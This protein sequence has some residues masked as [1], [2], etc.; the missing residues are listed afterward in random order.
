MSAC[1][2]GGLDIGSTT[3]KLVLLDEAL[4]IQFSEYRR[5]GAEIRQT[6]LNLLGEARQ[7][8]G[9][10][11]IKLQITGSGGLLLAEQIGVSFIQEVIAGT[12]AI[13]RTF[14]ETDVAIELGGEDAKITFFSNPMEQR[15]NGVCAGGTG[16]FIDQMAILLDTDAA[17]LNE[18]AKAYTTIHPI[19]S[20][21]G[22]FAKTDLQPLLNEGVP[23][24]DLAASIFQAVVNQTVSGLACGKS[25]SGKI[26]LL[27][28]P[29]YFLS[30][31]RKRFQE[32]LAIAEADLIVPEY[33]HYMVA[34]GTAMDAGKLLNSLSLDEVISKLSAVGEASLLETV[35]L[36]PLFA[37]EAD[38]GQFKKR[39]D[40]HKAK[41]SSLQSHS[42]PIFVGIDAGSTTTKLIAI[43]D[44]AEI[45]F[46]HYGSNLGSPL[47]STK[48]ALRSLYRRMPKDAFIGYSTVTGYGEHLL[49]SALKID[50]GEIETIA[51]YKAAEHFMPGVTFVIDIGGQDM[52]SLKVKGGMIESIMLN[53]ACSSG[54]GSFIETFAK[55]MG[56]NVI[57]F[58]RAGLLAT[59]PVDLGTRCTVF[60][61]S[62]VKQA[63]KEGASVADIS[64]GIAYSVVKNA[65]YKVI[66]LKNTKELGNKIVVQGGTFFN[67]AVLRAFELITGTE[68]VRPDISGLMGA[69]GAA[70]IAKDNFDSS[71]SSQIISLEDLDLLEM[72]SANERC[73]LCGNQCLL[74]VQTFT[75]GRRFVS[76]NRCERGAKEHAPVNK[77]ENFYDYKY[78][79]L[80]SY[81]P[82]SK[83]KA[84]R[85]TVGIPRVLNIYENYPF[86]FRFFSDL[87]FRVELSSRSS[88]EIYQKG[89]E[90]IPSESVCYPAKL[91]HGHIEDLVERGAK[92][93]FYPSIPYEIKES[94]EAD[95]H[96]N[97]PIVT[98]Y[99]ETIKL[100]VPSM[101]RSDIQYFNPFLPLFDRKKMVKIAQRELKSYD[102]DPRDIERAVD[103]AYGELEIYKNDL[104]IR[105]E[106]MIEQAR[107]EG[108]KIIVLS[109]RPYHIDPE[110]NH[111]IPQMIANYGL[112]VLSEDAITHL[113]ELDRPLR[114][115]DQ[116]AYHTRLYYAAQLVAKA[117]DMELVQ[118]TSFGCGLDA[119]T[120]DQVSEILARSGKAHTLLK[121]DEINNL[122]AAR[123]RIRS[124][125]AVMHERDKQH[126]AGVVMTTALS[127]AEKKAL[128]MKAP[129]AQKL[130]P[131]MPEAREKATFTKEMRHSHTILAP[132]MSPVHFNLFEA[133]FNAEDYNLVVLSEVSEKA[134]AE[135]LQYVHN[136][137]CYPS[138]VTIGQ[139]MSAL[140]SGQYDLSKTSVMISQ[141]GG[142]CRATN[143][144]GFLR[145]ALKDAELDHIPVISLNAGGLEKSPGFS[146]TPK[147]LHK[148]A[149]ALMYGDLFMRLVY[150][151]RPYERHKGATEAL[152]DHWQAKVKPVIE[153]GNLVQYKKD[154]K[155]IVTQFAQIPVLELEKPKVGIVGEILVKY[156]PGANNQLPETLER[157]GAEVIVP[158]LTDFLLYCAYNHT[159]K[160]EL[161]DTSWLS[162]VASDALIQFIE[163]YRKDL[164]EAL[165]QSGRFS[166]PKT[167]QEKAENAAKII[168]LGHQTGEGWFLTAEM[169]ELL[170]SGVNNIACLQ[171]FACLPNHIV[172]KG[173]IKALKKVYP[174]ANI[175]PVDYDAGASEVNQLNR[176]L[177]MMSNA[178]MQSS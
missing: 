171:P 85:G 109:G 101:E 143:Y 132:Q 108:R 50:E 178:Q 79:R 129:K 147:L 29:L 27:G 52:K 76:G 9:N 169:I 63:Q 59:S 97:C 46:E 156:H 62:K 120:A 134:I 57:D 92:L 114:V 72:T 153:K 74:S 4:S 81:K 1:L 98:S 95:N 68:V 113:C 58:A 42:G 53:E 83:E 160:R 44:R 161:L 118:L 107:K 47:E 77:G 89:M 123:I 73:T 125:M 145:K 141:T 90:S 65:L 138:I 170:E 60:M 148:L 140:K 21:C 121:I 82:L 154:V 103:C 35:T 78:Q 18:M 43:N 126:E 163:F 137:A 20:R 6:A 32:T 164:R 49:K 26:A 28:G 166:V 116:W 88:R 168:S 124:L 25:I 31:L 15:M 133:A 67:E 48:E 23:K 30:E 64:A 69:F 19:A 142:G 39:H 149:I 11:N 2:W 22:V 16:A 173:V 115:V 99:P 96:Y 172:G 87:G 10:I 94:L 7:A 175:A 176:I 71:L 157:M 61:N 8:L 130:R 139:I 127:E 146:L 55:A 128:Q 33:A 38:Y 144:I 104:R 155:D 102:I 86:W 3:V 36:K 136:D 174:K 93:I 51:H 37:T 165:L 5:H 66:R 91:V 111:G 84:F 24:A 110:I 75:G 17:G 112:T 41:R 152:Y 150:E 122:G 117:P 119:V 135:G 177:L 56:M 151:V 167:I 159:V 162:K 131:V 80:F 54:C 40:L 34:L 106:E 12:R 13:E 45:L 158:D 14:P 70:L 100:N 105:A